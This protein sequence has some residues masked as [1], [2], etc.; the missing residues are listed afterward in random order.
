MKAGASKEEVIAE[1]ADVANFAFMLADTYEA[2]VKKEK[3]T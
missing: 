2:P 3:K 1:A